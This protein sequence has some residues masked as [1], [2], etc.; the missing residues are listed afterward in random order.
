MKLKLLNAS[1]KLW[2]TEGR[3]LRYWLFSFPLDS[4]SKKLP[5]SYSGCS[6][7]DGIKIN[8]E[9]T[10]TAEINPGAARELCDCS[11]KSHDRDRFNQICPF[12]CVTSGEQTDN[13]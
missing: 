1:V 5:V 9:Q 4:F 10:P 7:N 11:F 3:R 6:L 8:S 13:R 12:V 2:A